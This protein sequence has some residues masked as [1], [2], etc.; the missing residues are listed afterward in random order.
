MPTKKITKT[1][2]EKAIET[3]EKPQE[4]KV[5]NSFFNLLEFGESYTSLI[6]GIIVVIIATVLLLTFVRNTNNTVNSPKTQISSQQTVKKIAL[7]S[8]AATS[9]VKPTVVAKSP[10]PTK[11][12][13]TPTI[14]K[15]PTVTNKPTPTIMPKVAAAKD[16]MVK[17]TTQKGNVYTVAE[18]DTLWKIAEAHYKSGYN[19]VD[20]ASAN[21]LN[22]PGAI[23]KGDKLILPKVEP[24]ITTVSLT[25]APKI[26]AAAQISP[27]APP[28]NSTV[29]TNTTNKITGPSYTVAKGDSLWNIAVRA[30]GDG[31]Q[32]V[33]IANANSLTNPGM[34]YSGN[35]LKIPR[36]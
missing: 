32:W 4:Q 16:T 31:Y 12:Q 26:V 36:A 28:A 2:K 19:W 15:I 13:P 33:K 1:A 3:P 6:L 5:K 8:Q 9:T 30:Y 21:N 10:T 34:I 7:V 35:V 17:Q 11:S 20:I 18:G 27:A 14:T 22:V 24:K 23:H 29:T 25:P